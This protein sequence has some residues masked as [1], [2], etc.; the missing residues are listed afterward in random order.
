M[1]HLKKNKK[2][3]YKDTFIIIPFYNEGKI[4]NEVINKLNF[5]F[6][7]IICVDDGST[8]EHSIYKSKLGVYLIKHPINLGQ[9]AALR[10]GAEYA[11]KYKSAT[12]IVTFDADGQQN[13]L[14]AKNML[15][16]L[17]S[18]NFDVVLGSR[19]INKP[20]KTMPFYRF[21]LLKLAILFTTFTARLQ[22]SDTHNGLRVFKS[23]AY[24]KLKLVENKMAHA[25]EII[26]QI[27]FHNLK[28]TEYGNKV[29]Y[30]KYSLSKG[31]HSIDAIRILL[32]LLT[33]RLFK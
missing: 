22:V 23:Q 29:E 5:F 25:S 13:P 21:L 18:K 19:F 26:Y 33:S 1:N 24:S 28:F 32:D 14:D 7:Y 9:G 8:I 12:E 15:N 20:P 30:T 10:T 3:L 17:R 4:L 6:D 31:Q 16:L 27:H 11:I 2:N